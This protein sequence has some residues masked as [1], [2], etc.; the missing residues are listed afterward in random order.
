MSEYWG[1]YCKTCDKS[2]D[3]EFNHGEEILRS[4]VKATPHLKAAFDIDTSGYFEFHLMGHNWSDVTGFALEEHAGHE[5]ELESEY[6]N[7]ETIEG[8]QPEGQELPLP[9]DLDV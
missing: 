1:L 4:L 7:R 8:P 6:G 9:R 3:H 2:T 5:L